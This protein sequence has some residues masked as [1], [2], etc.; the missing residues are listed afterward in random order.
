MTAGIADARHILVIKH[1]ALGD[2]I[3]ALGP[4]AAIRR[5]HPKARITLLTTQPFQALA[6]A[7]GYVDRVWLDERP[8]WH[9]IG[10]WLALRRRLRQ[11]GFQRVYDLQTSDRSSFYLRFF[12][13]HGRPQWSG[14]AAG[15]SHRHRHPERQRMHTLE[16]QRD[17]LKDIGIAEV[18]PPDLAWLTAELARFALPPSYALL[19]PG[20]ARH[21]P[22]K[23]WPWRHY[24]E[25]AARLAARGVVPMLLGGGDERALAETIAQEAPQ[26]RNLCGETSLFELAALARGARLAIGNDTGPMHL[27]AAV[28][29]PCLVLFSA[30]SDPARTAPRGPRVRVLRRPALSDLPVDEVWRAAEALLVASPAA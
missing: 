15:A 9:A 16:R 26:A 20:G 3:L 12:P 6:A 1:G 7:S 5:A 19:V 2:F 17:Q 18:P 27:A 14:I 8:K 4:L 21:R 22:L 13:R 10:R 25:L 29:A 11:G 28:G 24:G 30:A 23:R